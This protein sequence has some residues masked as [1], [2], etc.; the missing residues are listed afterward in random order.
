MSVIPTWI[1]IGDGNGPKPNPALTG[2]AWTA[3]LAAW[4][5][6]NAAQ[7]YQQGLQVINQFLDPLTS[8]LVSIGVGLGDA[9]SLEVIQWMHSVY[10]F[11]ANNV[12]TVQGWTTP[13]QVVAATMSYSSIAAPPVTLAALA[14]S[15]ITA[16]NTKYPGKV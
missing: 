13:Q 14:T 10:T 4:Q 16:L 15:V 5:S 6:N 12:A 3:A 1:D 2:A 11:Y 8:M 7:F 9:N